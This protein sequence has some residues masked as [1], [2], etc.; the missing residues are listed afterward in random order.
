MSILN[1]LRSFKPS[2]ALMCD[3]VLVDNIRYPGFDGV[4]LI[5]Q[6]QR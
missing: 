2:M 6:F 1:P 3:S 4:D 5:A